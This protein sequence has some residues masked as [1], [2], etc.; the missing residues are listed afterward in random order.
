MDQATNT[1]IALGGGLLIALLGW[2]FSSSKVETQV[3]DAD[4]A[5]SRFDGVTSFQLTFYRQSGNTHRVVQI[6]GTRE[7]VEAEIR[8]V[9]NRAG[10]RDQYMVGIRGDTIDYCRAYHNHRGSN[11][12]KKV[13]G[14]LVSAL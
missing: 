5:W 2:A 1:L 7:D 13:G 6:H 8:K 10:I 11:E 12:G 4:D 14:C 3:V 9:F